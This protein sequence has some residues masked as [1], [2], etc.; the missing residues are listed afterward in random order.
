MKKSYEQLEKSVNFYRA[1]AVFLVII[2]GI[3][4]FTIDV[5]E[6]KITEIEDNIS[7]CG[8]YADS[9]QR[10]KNTMQVLQL[11]NDRV[12]EL[13]V[14]NGTLMIQLDKCNGTDEAIKLTPLPKLKKA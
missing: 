4:V 9:E 7:K 6:D 3:A 10:F 13:E 14:A 12:S 8:G 2:I 11:Q 1:V 5:Q